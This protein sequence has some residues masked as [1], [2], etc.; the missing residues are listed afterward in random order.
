MNEGCAIWISGRG[1]TTAHTLVS[2]HNVNQM[3]Q[4]YWPQ[5]LNVAVTSEESAICSLL[6]RFTVPFI[7]DRPGSFTVMNPRWVILPGMITRRRRP[8]VTLA[9]HLIAEQRARSANI[10]MGGTRPPAFP[11]S[12]PPAV[13]SAFEEFLHTSNR[14]L[15]TTVPL[16]RSCYLHS[17]AA[18]RLISFLPRSTILALRGVS[19]TTKE[20]AHK[21]HPDL[22]TTLHLTCPLPRYPTRF[23][24]KTLRSLGPGCRQLTIHLL[25]SATQIHM[26][27]T[28]DP[29]PT[30]QIFNL[31]NS[32]QSLRVNAPLTDAFHPLFS[33]RLALEQAPLKSLT[34]LHFHHLTVPGLLGLRWG[35]FDAF[36]DATWMGKK[37]WRGITSLRIGMTTDWLQWAVHRDQ[38][39]LSRRESKM[40]KARDVYR[41][42]IQMLHDWFFHF[43]LSGHIRRLVFEWLGSSSSS[44]SSSSAD[45]QGPNPFLLDA[46]IGTQEKNSEWFSAPGIQW[47][48]V[49]EIWLGGIQVASS[50]VIELKSRFEG[51][52]TLMV[53]EAL[54]ESRIL[55]TVRS[56][57][58]REWLD[59]DLTDELDVEMVGNGGGKAVGFGELSEREGPVGDEDGGGDSMLCPFVLRL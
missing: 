38:L 57:E 32:I 10:A 48:G 59:V 12:R 51:L 41:Q 23:S 30:R 28:Q 43:S 11:A 14:P 53:W 54:A 34:E 49:R 9:H 46:E 16:R 15:S 26:G 21:H 20:W 33:L 31:V 55:G 36:V 22:L 19:R 37:F 17:D 7:Q 8:S 47:H 42:G 39:S 1:A 5:M 25:P 13:L 3:I 44:S 24:S 18:D 52:E 27:S 6:G 56:V 4:Q 58:G 45:V 50:D 29:S 35:G 40:Q 2:F